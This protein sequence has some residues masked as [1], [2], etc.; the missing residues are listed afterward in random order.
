L[1]SE[2][3]EEVREME[4]LEIIEKSDSPYASPLSM[5]MKKDGRNRPVT[6]F[7][8]LNKITIF[9]AEY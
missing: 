3:I 5:M 7:R 2:V 4:R 8:R 6:D 1:K 9:D